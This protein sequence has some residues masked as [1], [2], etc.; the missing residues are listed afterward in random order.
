M[1]APETF[2]GARAA[3]EGRPLR[4]AGRLNCEPMILPSAP[5]ALWL[6][7]ASAALAYALGAASA[8]RAGAGAHAGRSLWAMA[9][10]W[11]LHAVT[12]AWGLM[13]STPHFGFAPALSM[14][15]CVAL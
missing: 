1:R 11:V 5:L 13:G 8:A 12:L 4:G 9:P 14:T 3:P 7:A 10:A 15:A 6:L 2:E